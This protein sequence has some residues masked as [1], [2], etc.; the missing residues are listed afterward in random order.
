MHFLEFVLFY[1][2]Q[3]TNEFYK[4]KEK[5]KLFLNFITPVFYPRKK[6]HY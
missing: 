2:S 6:C 5:E 4:K 3:S 1:F